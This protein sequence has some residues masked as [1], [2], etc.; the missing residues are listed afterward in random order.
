MRRSLI[1]ILTVA[2]VALTFASSGC[3]GGASAAE[4]G[5]YK[6]AGDKK[7]EGVPAA[8]STFENWQ[9]KL[10]ETYSAAVHTGKVKSLDDYGRFHTAAGGYMAVARSAQAEYERIL[11]LKGVEDYK[12]YAMEM[13]DYSK[14][15]ADSLA[16]ARVSAK[17]MNQAL[18]DIAPGGKPDPAGPDK[19][20]K[21]QEKQLAAEMRAGD[22]YGAAYQI[23]CIE[24]H[25]ADGAEQSDATRPSNPHV[26]WTEDTDTTATVIWESPRWLKGYEAAVDFGEAPDRLKRS[27]E[28]EW[29]LSRP[30]DRQDNKA[31]LRGLQP[32]TTYY[33]RCGSKKYGM[34]DVLSFKTGPDPAKKSSFSCI[35]AGDTRS[36]APGSTDYKDWAAVA[37]A[38]SLEKAEFSIVDGGLTFFGFD[39]A[40]WPGWFNAAAP[41]TNTG[42][43][44]PSLGNHEAYAQAFFDTFPLRNNSRWFYYD[45]GPVRFICLDSGLLDWVNQPL[46]EKQEDWLGR[47]I[48]RAKEKGSWV[49]V[50]MHRP[51]YSSTKTGNETDI[52]EVWVPAF[53]RQQVD[54]VVGAHVH[55]YERSLP[56]KGGK[57]VSSEPNRYSRNVGV[58]YLTAGQAGAPVSAPAQADWLAASSTARG[59]SLMT[60]A[61]QG[62][63]MKVETKD[64]SGKVIDWFEI[65]R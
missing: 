30:A 57:A 54:L 55:C 63:S 12:A 5:R 43:L 27:A 16:Q 32:S 11:S 58:I 19:I 37:R 40:L 41:L 34:S 51:A 24:L 53:D 61:A 15:I 9:Y 21:A 49:V 65:T 48:R 38:A 46:L 2:L 44:M 42:V 35:L 31:I 4:A 45:V 14:S 59:Y 10:S 17:V 36:P 64:V 33:Y 47:N 22:Y 6:A 39:E 23:D 52:D 13:I 28:G 62:R 1:L 56:M 26:T 25:Q 8:Y 29:Y 3:A 60:V 20:L 18:V 7:A 50:Y